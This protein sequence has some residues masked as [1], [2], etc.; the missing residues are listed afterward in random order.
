MKSMNGPQILEKIFVPELH[1]KYRKEV[2]SIKKFEKMIA[3]LGGKLVLDHGATRTPEKRMHDFLTRIAGSMGLKP[4]QTYNFPKKKLTA[5]DMQLP[6]KDDFKWFSTLIE[7]KKFS[8]EAVKAIDEDI[9][10]S[11][12]A[13]SS[14]GMKLL[15]KLEKHGSLS[16]VEA[17]EYVH[18]ILY[19]FLKRTGA[20]VKKS[21]LDLVAKESQEIYNA[22]LLGPDFNHIAYTLNALDIKDWYGTEIIEVLNSR[23][24]KEGFE[25]LPEIQGQAGGVLRQTS[26][27]ADEMDFPAEDVNGKIVKVK[28]PGK[29]VEL[30]QRGT[31]R[32]EEGKVLFER[33]KAKVYRGFVTDNT[34]KLYEA[35]KL[36]NKNS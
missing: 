20:P 29:F 35:T 34:E 32:D 1:E 11:K 19:N 17:K 4:N 13:L 33:G 14:K 27:K 25:M 31:E 24:L 22:L 3:E 7:Y 21:T 15:E 28:A 18:E 23:M 10:R 26:T 12:I 9:G 5:I 6:N 30:I 16:E 36:K 8:P 2:P